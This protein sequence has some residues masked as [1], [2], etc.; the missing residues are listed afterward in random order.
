M[1]N[2]YA[3]SALV[4]ESAGRLH[5]ENPVLSLFWARHFVTFQFSFVVIW[6][7]L[8]C[9]N[10]GFAKTLEEMLAA[11]YDLLSMVA[12]GAGVWVP[13]AILALAYRRMRRIRA[14]ATAISGS[15]FFLIGMLIFELLGK[16]LPR[17]MSMSLSWTPFYVVVT[18]YVALSLAAVLVLV[19]SQSAG[20]QAGG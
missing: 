13:H 15:A 10:L 14:S 11:P 20:V 1:T 8:I 17:G 6:F 2:P 5:C 16:F 3:P 4:H 12:F 7:A 9:A 18:L 19:R